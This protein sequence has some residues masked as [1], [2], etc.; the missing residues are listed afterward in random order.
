MNVIRSEGSE[1]IIHVLGCDDC[2]GLRHDQNVVSVLVVPP[3]AGVSK[4][5]IDSGSFLYQHSKC[6]NGFGADR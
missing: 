3:G 2:T 6:L 1:R 5:S 4:V